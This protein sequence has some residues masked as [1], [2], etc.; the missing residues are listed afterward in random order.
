VTQFIGALRNCDIHPYVV[1]DGCADFSALKWRTGRRRALERMQR[2]HHAAQSGRNA[3]VL[4]ALIWEV[5]RQT[6]HRLKVPLARS[7]TEADRQVAA[8]AQEW[9][10]PVLSNNS[11]F[12]IFPLTRGM[13]HIA[14]FKWKNVQQREGLSFIPCKTYLSS[15]FCETVHIGPQLLPVFA[16][17]AGNDYTK[18]MA[19]GAG[20]TSRDISPVV[21]D[22]MRRPV[23]QAQ[24][25]SDFLDVLTNQRV[26]LSVY[27]EQ[28]Q[29]TAEQSFGSCNVFSLIISK[30]LFLYTL[31][32]RA[33]QQLLCI[34]TQFFCT[35]FYFKCS[36]HVKHFLNDDSL[37]SS[38]LVD[39]CV[40]V[41]LF[42]LQT[43][44]EQR[45]QVLLNALGVSQLSSLPSHLSDLVL[46]LAATCFWLKEA[47]PPPDPSLLK[48]LLIGWDRGSWLSC[49]PA[50]Y[51]TVSGLGQDLDK[52]WCH[53][54]N[55]WQSCL[56]DSFLLNQLLGA[57]L[58]EPPMARL[59]S[60]TLVHDLLHKMKSGRLNRSLR[61]YIKGNEDFN[62]LLFIA[63]E[64]QTGSPVQGATASTKSVA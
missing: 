37:I 27:Q 61:S 15:R 57:P 16:V 3:A 19:G 45:R 25:S 20:D 22:W 10:C 34:K 42:F 18:N 58:P 12:A 63:Q 53:W 8:L 30:V 44:L 60:G 62:A 43:A 9:G 2:A 11:D 6:L 35:L 47:T 23:I 24:F 48:A 54:L 31:F 14:H 28:T 32:K 4:P 55:Q 5:F 33:S 13:L 40:K 36:H 7:Y 1:F 56:R 64:S 41:S 59:F 21:P 29:E 26:G 50:S 38:R 17:L 51:C 49:A 46:P 52:D 39:V